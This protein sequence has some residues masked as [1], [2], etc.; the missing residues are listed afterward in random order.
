MLPTRCPSENRQKHC[1]PLGVIEVGDP[2]LIS[3]EEEPKFPEFPSQLT[4][5]RLIERWPFARKAV[6]VA[7][8]DTELMLVE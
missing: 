3:P 8:S 4:S 1:S 6:D 2:Y 7:K 5:L